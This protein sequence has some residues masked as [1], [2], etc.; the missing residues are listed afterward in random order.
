MIKNK[1]WGNA[2]S[3]TALL[4]FAFFSYPFSVL[5]FLIVL[6]FLLATN[7]NSSV[8]AGLTRNPLM[9]V[10]KCLTFIRGSRVKHGMTIMLV[11]AFLLITAFCLYKQ[12]PVYKAYKTWNSSRIYYHA[13]MYKESTQNYEPLYPYLNDQIQFLFE[14]AQSLS[15]SDDKGIAGQAR[16]D[17]YT[18]VRHDRL[19]RSNEVLQRAMQISCDP[20]L[21]NII[22][23][24][25][26]AMKEYEQ[27][28]AAFLQSTRIVPNRLYPWYLLCK[29][30]AETGN[31]EKMKEMAEIVQTKEPK[32]QSPAVREMRE[33]VR[34]LKDKN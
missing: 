33:E 11:V 17:S 14:Y 30:H 20:M 9:P 24:N 4:V 18:K 5:P 7:T 6:V 2:G 12:Y 27:A 34:K 3:L 8:I 28:E 13:G 31:T 32:V 15:K 23:K 22:G 21:Y 29:L 19:I 10:N 16:N 26:Q 25:Y 1:A